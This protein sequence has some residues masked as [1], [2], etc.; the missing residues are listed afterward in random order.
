MTDTQP[1][2]AM[3]DAGAKPYAAKFPSSPTPMR[4]TPHHHITEV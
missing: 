3:S 2:G 1:S 4:V